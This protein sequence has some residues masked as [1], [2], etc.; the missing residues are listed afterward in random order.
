VL[1][2][3]GISKVRTLEDVKAALSTIANKYQPIEFEVTSFRTKGGKV[4]NDALI[5]GLAKEDDEDIPF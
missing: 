3:F 4:K 1:E 5:I 2:A